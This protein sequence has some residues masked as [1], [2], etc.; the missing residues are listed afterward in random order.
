MGF[1]RKKAPAR[2]GCARVAVIAGGGAKTA[3]SSDIASSGS[4]VQAAPR[5]VSVEPD[6]SRIQKSPII[7]TPEVRKKRLAAK[8]INYSATIL[9]RIVIIAAAC[10]WGYEQMKTTGVVH[11]G[12]AAG[13]FAMF[14]DLGRVTM[15][16]LTPGSK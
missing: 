3:M 10:M 14:L 15:K 11:R 7:E 16:A 1:G 5:R 12:V 2:V 8:T 4:G 9:A 6:L 13:V